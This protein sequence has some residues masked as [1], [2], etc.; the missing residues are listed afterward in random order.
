[1][2]ISKKTR[3]LERATARAP[4]PAP[5]RLTEHKSQ[6]QG[7]RVVPL[8][9][10][11]DEADFLEETTKALKDSG[12]P[13]AN[14]SMIAQVAVNLLMKEIRGKSTEEIL[15]YFIRQNKKASQDLS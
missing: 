4:K 2:A 15:L 11:T 13:K 6:K 14:R 5:E 9:F 7:Y 8:S 10:Y 3:L 12:F 1:M